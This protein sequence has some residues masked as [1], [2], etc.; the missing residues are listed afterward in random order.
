MDY[1]SNIDI[2]QST[3]SYIFTMADGPVLSSSKHQQMVTL[4]TMEAKYMAMMCGAQQ[5]L[6]MHNFL[7]EI[8]LDQ[9][10][11]AK[12]YVNNNSSIALAQSTKGHAYAKHIDI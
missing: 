10:L 2:Q 9:P 1:G 3:S 11:P 8:N 7:S 12:L 5:A 6:W 4:S